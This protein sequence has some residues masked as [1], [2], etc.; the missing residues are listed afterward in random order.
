[1]DAE[2]A[3]GTTTGRPVPS[4]AVLASTK[5][6]A[7]TSSNTVEIDR[8]GRTLTGHH[9]AC[10]HTFRPSGMGL[11]RIER[12]PRA[13]TVSDDDFCDLARSILPP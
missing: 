1:V 3:V 11:R 8:N 6:V 4:S 13:P 5:N 10:S 9:E 12:S 7:L 2:R